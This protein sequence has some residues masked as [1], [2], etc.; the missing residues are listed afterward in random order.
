MW[1]KRFTIS[2]LLMLGIGVLTIQ[3]QN[4]LFVKEKNGTQT[5]TTLNEI[6]KLSFHSGNLVVTKTNST[7][8]SIPL[9]GVRILSFKNYSTNISSEFS[10][11]NTI[12]SLYPNPSSDILTISLGEVDLTGSQVE[13]L[14]IR[15]Q[16]VQN[17]ILQ[18]NNG[19]IDIS[20]L[21]TGMYVLR[22]KSINK[23]STIKFIKN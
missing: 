8:Q 13:I 11:E 17:T 20:G 14:N 2:A 22:I 3:A 12:L 19:K 16:L 10:K 1:C 9:S 7:T 15:G 5:N 6:R 4:S 21:I 23:F 18:N